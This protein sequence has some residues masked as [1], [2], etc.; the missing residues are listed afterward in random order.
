MATALP[1]IRFSSDLERKN[2]EAGLELARRRLAGHHI[3]TVAERSAR[4]I[5]EGHAEIVRRFGAASALKHFGIK[6]TAS[7]KRLHVIADTAVVKVL[8]KVSSPVKPTA[9]KAPTH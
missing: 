7:N 9:P 6:D 4:T 1:T 3:E 5:R 8:A 2:Y